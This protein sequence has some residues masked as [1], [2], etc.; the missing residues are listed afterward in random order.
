MEGP[1]L[2]YYT[3]RSGLPLRPSRHRRYPRHHT[4]RRLPTLHTYT[5]APYTARRSKNGRPLC[6]F[7]P[8]PLHANHTHTHT[9]T[10]RVYTCLCSPR[11]YVVILMHTGAGAG[12]RA[13]SF[14]FFFFS[15]SSYPP[16]IP[17][18]VFYITHSSFFYL[19]P[20]TT[21]RRVF[22]YTYRYTCIYKKK[23][24]CVYTITKYYKVCIYTH[25]HTHLRRSFDT[26]Q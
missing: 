6:P 22:M 13:R 10:T 15:L 7:P 4:L 25:T 8:I 12:A 9:R 24:D 16:P 21:P 14:F 23:Y 20:R 18:T 5:L 17:D 1:L 2:T 11:I 3:H 26:I 19:P